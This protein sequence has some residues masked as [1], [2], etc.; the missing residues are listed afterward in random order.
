MF[1]TWIVK[2]YQIKVKT[3]NGD[4]HWSVNSDTGR[5]GTV[6]LYFIITKYRKWVE[7][8]RCIFKKKHFFEMFTHR[9]ILLL[10]ILN[11][12]RLKISKNCNYNRIKLHFVK[13]LSLFIFSIICI[14]L[15]LRYHKEDPIFGVWLFFNFEH[16][17]YFKSSFSKKDLKRV[18]ASWLTN[19]FLT[20]VFF[21]LFILYFDIKRL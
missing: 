4:L 14:E 8:V 3:I 18:T 12:H 19:Y 11:E 1:I 5:G 15:E 6:L 16:T 2:C 13:Y 9:E 7:I 17:N 21:V 10:G 20:F